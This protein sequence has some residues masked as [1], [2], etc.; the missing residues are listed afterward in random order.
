MS[1]YREMTRTRGGRVDVVRLRLEHDLIAE[2]VLTDSDGQV[3]RW[4]WQPRPLA[5][6]ASAR[7]LAKWGTAP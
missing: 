1:D 6:A 7:D 3:W 2:A 5:E 4:S